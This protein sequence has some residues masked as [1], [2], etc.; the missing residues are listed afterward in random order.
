MSVIALI[1]ARGGSKR[2][3]GKNT[4]ECA[5]RPLLGWTAEAALDSRGIDRAILSTDDES[6]AQVGRDLGLEVPFLRP[7]ELSNDAAPMAP[8]MQ[9]LLAWLVDSGEDVEALVLLQPSSPLRQAR[10]I[11]E[12]LA[13][14]FD[15]GAETV[16]SVVEVPHAFHPTKLLRIDDGRLVPYH[17]DSDGQ[18][19]PA[20]GRNGPAI[21]INRPDV[22]SRGER[23]GNPTMP[24][25]M[26][27]E[28]SID[29]DEPFDL[30]FAAFLL[31][32]RRLGREP[33]SQ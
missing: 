5:G 18:G 19:A 24:Y 6:I 3:P 1:P 8:V 25:L 22:I 30:E 33:A 29:I 14:F 11:D 17:Q 13:I 7:T 31:E 9:H 27:P 2:V 12:A 32:K 23:W 28:L 4:A 26:A 10:H 20:F 21:L 16:V 15:S